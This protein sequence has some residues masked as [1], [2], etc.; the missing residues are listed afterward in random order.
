ML[1]TLVTAVKTSFMKARSNIHNLHIHTYTRT[2]TDRQTDR[3]ICMH[4][5]IHVA[6]CM[7]DREGS[8]T[9]SRLEEQARREESPYVPKHN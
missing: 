8:F 3:P 1:I 7:V 5:Y 6:S 2:Q 4:M 9:T